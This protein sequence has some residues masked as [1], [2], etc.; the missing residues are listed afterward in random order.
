M[1][2]AERK[3][4][5]TVYEFARRHKK[6]LVLGCGTCV[7]VCM[8]GGKK[9]A[10]IL[11]SQLTLKARQDGVDLEV[12]EHTIE[13]QCDREFFDEATQRKIKDADAVISLAC[14]V[15][16]Q[17]C[18]E[19]LPDAIVYPGVDTK[20]YGATIEQGLWSERC[21]GCGNCVLEQFGGLCPVARCSK[22]LLNGPCGGSSDGKCEVNSDIDCIWQLIYDRMKKLGRLD[23][24]EQN[25][26]AKDWTTGR[27][28][29][30]RRILREDVTLEANP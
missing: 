26:P 20:F 17:F 5:D 24:L 18:I 25:Q 13:R 9:E 12:E 10:E 7:T 15:G 2:T 16:V 21:G 22:S 6:V 30:P 29:G 11:T 23:E 4:F 19:V 3:P 14:G 28:G 1:I 27:D 8:A